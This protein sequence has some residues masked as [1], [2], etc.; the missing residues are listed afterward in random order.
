MDFADGFALRSFPTMDRTEQYG[1]MSN[2]LTVLAVLKR[3]AP[4]SA[5]VI[6]ISRLR[7]FVWTQLDG[8][9]S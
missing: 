7:S 8:N 4:M 6:S 5:D 9:Q 1:K 3:K 2:F